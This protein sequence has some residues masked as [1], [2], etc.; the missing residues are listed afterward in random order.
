MG[1]WG[2]V[3]HIEQRTYTVCRHAGSTKERLLSLLHSRAQNLSLLFTRVVFGRDAGSAIRVQHV[4]PG[5]GPAEPLDEEFLG[6][7]LS[8]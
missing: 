7:H 6:D 1:S 2:G 3:S 4:L 5:E 8:L